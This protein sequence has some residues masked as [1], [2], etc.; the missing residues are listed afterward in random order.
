MA[1][2]TSFQIDRNV[3]PIARVEAGRY[4]ELEVE[5][6][7]ITDDDVGA[8]IYPIVT[9]DREELIQHIVDATGVLAT[10]PA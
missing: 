1:T 2:I 10:M 8:A 7:E 4:A 3:G 6:D 5:T 9:M